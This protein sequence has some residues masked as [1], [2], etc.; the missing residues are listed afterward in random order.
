MRFLEILLLLLSIPQH[1]TMIKDVALCVMNFSGDVAH[2]C[3]LKKLFNKM[4]VVIIWYGA[5]IFIIK[6]VCILIFFEDFL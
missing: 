6:V 2:I 4:K 5:I 3:E 1:T